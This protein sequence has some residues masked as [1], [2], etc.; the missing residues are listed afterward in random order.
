MEILSPL[1]NKLQHSI[2]EPNKF[3]SGRPGENQ[4]EHCITQ[5][6]YMT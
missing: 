6:I 4:P 1:H 5:T 2:A 3:I